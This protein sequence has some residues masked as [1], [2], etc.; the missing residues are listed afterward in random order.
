[1]LARYTLTRSELGEVVKLL[2]ADVDPS[3]RQIHLPRFN[4][5]PAQRCVIA[6]G[7]DGASASGA[8]VLTA[9]A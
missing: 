7:G 6:L 9:A 1:M 3:A 2:G 5:G 4:V 8:P